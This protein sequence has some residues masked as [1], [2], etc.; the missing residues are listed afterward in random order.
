MY[1][2][3]LYRPKAS[4]MIKFNERKLMSSVRFLSPWADESSGSRLRRKFPDME[5]RC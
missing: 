2:A 5:D 3:G 1:K 4:V